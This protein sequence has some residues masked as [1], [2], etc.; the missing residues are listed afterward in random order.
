MKKHLMIAAISLPLT[1]VFGNVAWA[2]KGNP[3]AAKEKATT[4]CAACH[5]ADGNSPTPSFPKLAGQN[6]DYLQVTLKQYRSKQRKNAIMNGQAE[7][8]TDKE[9]ADLSAY[10]AAQKGLY[11]KR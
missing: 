4:I 11:L 7:K 9:I 10:Y 3:A 2:A 6:A 8:L 1:L 5:G